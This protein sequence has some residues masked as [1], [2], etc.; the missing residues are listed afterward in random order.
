M[1]V[2][3]ADSV[4]TAEYDRSPGEKLFGELKGILMLSIMPCVES[5][6]SRSKIAIAYGT[7]DRR[8]SPPWNQGYRQPTRV[9]WFDHES[10]EATKGIH[11][12]FRYGM[13]ILCSITKEKASK[14]VCLAH[15]FAV[16]RKVE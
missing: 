5:A 2:P 4:P 14:L 8:E 11:G 10:S 12:Y 1:L 16:I 3:G 15:D 6:L 7:R 9:N 13:T